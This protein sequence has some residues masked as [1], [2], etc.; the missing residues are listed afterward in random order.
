MRLCILCTLLFGEGKVEERC[1]YIKLLLR[2][3]G[4]VLNWS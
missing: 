4:E 3:D 1:G 2:Y